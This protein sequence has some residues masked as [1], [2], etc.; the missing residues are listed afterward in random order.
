MLHHET[1]VLAGK[2]GVAFLWQQ[3]RRVLLWCR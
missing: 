1:F 3:D 2:Q